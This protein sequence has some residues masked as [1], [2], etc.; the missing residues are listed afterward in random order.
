ME[1]FTLP[2]GFGDHKSELGSFFWNE[3]TF[4]SRVKALAS[5]ESVRGERPL[6]W[7]QD[8]P[9]ASLEA[10]MV[11]DMFRARVEQELEEEVEDWRVTDFQGDLTRKAILKVQ[12]GQDEYVHLYA[13]RHR[14]NE[15]WGCLYA[16]FKTPRCTLEL[17]EDYYYDLPDRRMCSERFDVSSCSTQE[18]CLL[19]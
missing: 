3:R 12:V 17:T 2:A 11:A 1:A 5:L 16:P 7:Q 15:P 9:M 8:G 13:T 19:M 18:M 10:Q 6:I 4:E 14:R